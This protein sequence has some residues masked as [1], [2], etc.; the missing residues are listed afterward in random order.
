MLYHARIRRMRR[1][2]EQM[3][4]EPEEAASMAASMVSM[5]LDTQTHST[6]REIYETLH[7]WYKKGRR[8]NYEDDT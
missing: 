1:Y 4:W 8:A 2:L 6:L 7:T 5:G 3:G